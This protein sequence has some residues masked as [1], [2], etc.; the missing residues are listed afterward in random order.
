MT[1]QIAL[2]YMVAG[3]S[4]RFGGKIKGLVRVGKNGERL[5]EYSLDQAI[6]HGFDKIIF[7]TSDKTIES[8]RKAFGDEYKEIPVFYA[9]QKFDGRTRDK[10]WGTADAL[11]SA[12]EYL[13]CSFVVCNGDDIYGKES[14]RLLANHLRKSDEPATIGYNL[15]S[16]IPNEG[17]VNRGIFKVNKGY[18]SE[19]KETLGINRNNLQDSGL[20]LNNLCSMNIFALNLKTFTLLYERVKKFKEEHKNDRKAE[21]FLPTE[22]SYL[23]NEEKIKMKIYSSDYKCLGITN[24]GDEEVLREKL[25]REN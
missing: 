10:P 5:V 24:P 12:K 9:L 6:L 23:I 13:N 18:A 16:N 20:S 1:E 21:C 19:I 7:V 14:F 8:Y 17:S 25:K 2:V 11:C 3:L 4:S 22:I 15:G